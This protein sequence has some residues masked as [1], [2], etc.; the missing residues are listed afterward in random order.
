MGALWFI[1]AISDLS[2]LAQNSFDIPDSKI[3]RNYREK[4]P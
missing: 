2:I 1:S 4:Y 3:I